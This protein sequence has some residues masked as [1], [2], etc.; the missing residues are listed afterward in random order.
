MPRR[1]AYIMSRFPHLPETFILR[2]MIT[3][4]QLGWNIELYPLIPQKQPVTHD[5]A[6]PWA[7]RMHGARFS[8]LL[9][10]NLRVLLRQPI[11]YFHTLAALIRH[12]LRSPGFLLRAVYLF[13]QAV[14]MADSMQGEQV[15]HIHAH[16]ATHPALVAWIIHRLTGISYTVTVHAHDIFVDRTMLGPK[17]HDA[18]WVVAIS[19]FNREFLR[20]HLGDWIAGKTQVIHCGIETSQYRS[21]P[22][23]G[24][25][26]GGLFEVVNIGSLQPYKG[27]R[28]LI[29]GCAILYQRGVRFR[30]RIIG[31]GEL[32][33]A[34]H[35]Q[36]AERGL[37][38]CVELL[39]AKTQQE[40]TSLLSEADCYVQPSIITAEGK[41]EG[42]PVS[43]ME[44]MASGVP[45]IA[46]AI[47]GVPELVKEGETGLLV[48]PESASALADALQEVHDHPQEAHRRVELARALVVKEFDLRRNVA[49]LD[50]LISTLA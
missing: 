11:Q 18:A 44:A 16:Y 48:P 32:Y 1:I 35:A 34:L 41:M 5:E 22:R 30:C 47:S 15:S 13:P 23:D 45:V 46:T 14:W 2:E 49:E 29:E 31:G 43:L 50:T 39:G 12:N 20:N 28:T 33:P 36:I 17:L 19:Q 3:M 40:V 37:E 24:S 6:E 4:E 9:R 7:R 42:I 25:R 26:H 27:Q 10:A 38:E 21:A 8:S